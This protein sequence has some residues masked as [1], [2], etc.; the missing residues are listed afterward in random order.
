[1]QPTC[2]GPRCAKCL[3]LRMA[4]RMPAQRLRATATP[5]QKLRYPASLRYHWASGAHAI[6]G[7]DSEAQKLRGGS[8]G[9]RRAKW[10]EHAGNVPTRGCMQGV[11]QGFWYEN[12]RGLY[13]SYK[14]QKFEPSLNTIWP[15]HPWPTISTTCPGHPEPWRQ[16]LERCKNRASF[17]C[18]LTPSKGTRRLPAVA[19]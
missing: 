16:L 7:P 19:R 12:C 1:M 17:T 4:N 14:N 18:L 15:P 13:A 5:A 10:A 6:G 8:P 9:N 3:I 11:C 2:Q